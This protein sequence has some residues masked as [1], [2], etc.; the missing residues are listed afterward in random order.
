MVVAGGGDTAFAVAGEE[1]FDVA[2]LFILGKDFGAALLEFG[3]DLRGIALHS[4]IEIAQGSTGNEVADGPAR[5]IDVESKC[6]GEFLDAQH[7]SALFRRKPAFQQ[8]HIVWHCAP[9]ASGCP[10]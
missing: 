9:S 4:E 6:C 10:R 2:E 8:K 1:H 3:S 7:Y 5:Q